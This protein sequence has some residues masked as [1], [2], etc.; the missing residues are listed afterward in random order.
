MIGRIPFLVGIDQLPE[1][2]T[3]N[4]VQSL[5]RA[6]GGDLIKHATT[7][8]PRKV[9]ENLDCPHGLVLLKG[10]SASSLPDGGSWLEALGAWQQPVILMTTPMLSGDISG[11]ACAHVALCSTLSV[12]LVGILQIGGNW[13]PDARREDGLP[14]CGMIPEASCSFNSNKSVGAEESS[15]KHEG[16]LLEIA[17]RLRIRLAFL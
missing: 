1:I 17:E 4:A 9:L 16:S 3:K 5:S 12:P 14:W 2:L 15:L 13:N 11:C 7:E 8:K 10:D 6:W